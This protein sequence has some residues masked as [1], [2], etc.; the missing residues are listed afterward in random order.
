MTLN[1]KENQRIGKIAGSCESVSGVGQFTVQL[2]HSR[3][4]PESS[5]EEKRF[6]GVK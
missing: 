2:Y 4:K 5:V 1:I 3:G 6:L